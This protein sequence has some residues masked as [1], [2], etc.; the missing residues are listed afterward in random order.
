MTEAMRGLTGVHGSGGCRSE[1]AYVV[2]AG[3]LGLAGAPVP[4][5]AES[6]RFGAPGDRTL[7]VR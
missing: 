5:P 2:V 7:A 1:L 6:R 3:T 4:V